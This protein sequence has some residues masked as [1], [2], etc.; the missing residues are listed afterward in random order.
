MSLTC[1]VVINTY[2]RASYLQRLLLSLSHLQDAE[3]EVIVV[4][5]PS[6]DD[7]ELILAPYREQ[8]KYRSCN[9]RN[10]SQSRNIGIA[11]AA[12]DIV[13]FIDDDA[14]PGDPRWLARF[15]D[16]FSADT[17]GQVGALGGPVLHRDTEQYEFKGGRSSD[18]GFQIFNNHESERIGSNERW[19]SGIRG[20]NCAFL[21]KSLQLIGG[22]DEFFTYYLD[23]TDVCVRLLRAGFT[24]VYLDDNSV[25]HYAAPAAYR[26]N[27][28]DRNWDVITRS[29]T[30]FALKNGADRLP[31]RILK[32]LGAA[33]QK[34]YF[35]EIINYRRN[36]EI[37]S[38][39][40]FRLLRQ[41]ASG[42]AAGFVAGLFH[43]RET[44]QFDVETRLLPFKTAYAD[45]RMRVAL[46]SQAVPGQAS[47][48][49]I[50]RYTFDL[51]Q[52]LHQQ[53]HEVHIICRD[54][55]SVSHYSL[56]FFLH[57]ISTTDIAEQ[58]TLL[59]HPTLN[60]NMIYSLAVLQKLALLYRQG[61]VFDI[62]HAS[63]WDGEAVALI[64]A[65]VYPTVL[66]LVSPLAQVIQTEQWQVTADLQAC[67]AIDRWQIEHADTISVPSEGVLGSYRTLMQIVP[68]QLTSLRYA[69]LGIVPDPSGPAQVQPGTYRLLFVGRCERRKGVHILLAVLPQLLLAHPT[70]ECHL[71]GNDEIPLADGGTLKE[72]F[73]SQHQGADWLTRVVFHGQ[74]SEYELRQQYRRCDLFV[75]PSLF[76]SFG[77]IYHEAMQYGKAVVGCRTGGVPEV[78]TDGVEGLLVSPGNTDEL[79]QALEQLMNDDELRARMGE[80]GMRRIHEQVNNR[81][82]AARLAM[83]YRETIDKCAIRAQ[84]RRAQLWPPAL[85]IYEPDETIQ[86]SGPWEIREIHLGQFYCY[87]EPGATLQFKAQR[88]STIQIVGL[89]HGWSG[90]VQVSVN[91]TIVRYIDLYTAAEPQL[92]HMVAVPLL[93]V[94]SETVCVT[95]LVHQER[96]PASHATQVW[97]WNIFVVPPAEMPAVQNVPDTNS[98]EQ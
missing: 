14:I 75:A 72:R 28:Y 83:I 41:W 23:E 12:G 27:Q 55:L 57:G 63:N 97:L 78:V 47:Y 38:S 73:L 13:V 34:H 5:G 58:P 74:I 62:V 43:P 89:R 77:L 19:F 88:G 70:W 71:V 4:N 29:D 82:M 16:A 95:L 44:Q 30:Y 10:L 50:A 67:M 3:F 24:T 93:D 1:S 39:H 65:G 53:G 18:Y 64:R 98:Q 31:R 45:Q 37:A 79:Y 69:P 92:Q 51:A 32:T 85:P 22:F 52:G 36:R 33:P 80:C 9:T 84:R 21:R 86:F 68:E 42:L 61:I 76:E 59:A 40:W 46:L 15:I 94:G 7:T 66:M 2:N 20:C 25:R 91:D 11:A 6:T 35:T 54:E 56:G 48:G 26:T 49:G 87:G 17:T 96:N 81:T 90:I 8:I 60:R